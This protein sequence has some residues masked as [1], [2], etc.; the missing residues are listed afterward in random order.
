MKI[1]IHT[2]TKRCKSGD[3]HT[4]EI[5]PKKFCETVVST[6]VGIIAITNHNVF[7]L[8]QYKEILVGMNGNVQVWPGVELDIVEDGARGHLLVIVAP[9]AADKFSK[10]VKS[11]TKDESPDT[12][13]VAIEEVLSG[14]D[15]MKPLYVAHYKQKQPGLPDA[16]LGKLLTGTKNPN[17]VLKEVTNSISAGIYISHGYGSIYGSDLHDWAKYAECAA[18]LPDLRLP[19]D[20][21]EHFCLLLNKDPTTINTVLDRKTPEQLTL[22]PFDDGSVLEVRAYNDINV[23][24]GPK[25]TG[26]SCILRAIAKHYTESGIDASVYVSASGRLDEI[27]DTAGAKLGINLNDHQINYCQNE[28]SALHEA[29]EVDVTSLAKYKAYY[30][31]DITNKNAKKILLKDIEP[32]E[33]GGPKRDFQGF[34][35]ALKMTQEFLGFLSANASVKQVLS[36]KERGQL[37]TLLSVL[38][39]RL[40]GR[41]WSSFSEWKEIH[42]LN[43]AIKLFRK[44]VERKTGKPA[45]PM[46]T[47]F[48]AYAKNRIAIERS[49]SAIVKSI[50]TGIPTLREPIGSLGP[51]KGELELLTEFRFQDGN[52]TDGSLRA[53]KGAKKS[54]IKKFVHG[55]REVL[56]HVY[57]DDLFQCISDLNEIEDV[58]AITTVYEVLLFKRYFALG[59]EQYEPSSGEASMV[60]LQKELGTD[61]DVYILDEPEMSL[62]NEYISDVI[63]PL[64]KERARE[65]KR[66]FISTHD[67]NIAVRTLPYSSIYR[68]H[69]KEGYSTYI[70]NPFTNNLVNPEDATDKMDWKKVSMRTLEGGEDAF[71]ERGNIYGNG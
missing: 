9:T 16:A 22:R 43:S 5:A 14:F 8:A 49:A 31:S 37:D 55:V 58:E 50:E 18:E 24:F 20:S 48:R 11:L 63:V 54:A 53:I 33:Y 6:D 71:G 34:N 28:I 46:N 57:S 47:G 60:M 27:Y 3:A 38:A 64:L 7:D 35:E 44:E 21:F 42:L 26:K 19:V 2:H 17:F 13:T 59:G 30:Q 32:E 66:V 68:C 10:V 52:V 29:S 36:M 23:V 65:N 25:G 12:F 1:D 15:A 67:A 4:R 62:G 51:E 61:K 39:S 40:G 45:M 56:A 70:G 69:S 41:R